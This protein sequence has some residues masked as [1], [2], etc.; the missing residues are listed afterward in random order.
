VISGIDVVQKIKKNDM[1]KRITVKA[2]TP[3]PK[4]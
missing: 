4:P 2:G 3:A 1:I